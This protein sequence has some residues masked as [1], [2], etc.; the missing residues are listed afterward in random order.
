M[1]RGFPCQ[2]WLIAEARRLA[3]SPSLVSCAAAAGLVGRLWSP[4]EAARVRDAVMPQLLAGDGPRARSRTW[5][6]ALGEAERAGIEGGGIVRALSLERE[7]RPLRRLVAARL[8]DA[9]DLALSWLHARDDLACVADVLPECD[10][11]RGALADLDRAATALLSTWSLVPGLS[12]DER[13][14]AVSWQDPEAWWGS[15]CQ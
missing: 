14:R 12:R 5:G 3:A 11:L 7:L 9:G 15:L 4:P 10:A 6:R 1:I 8:A 13:L 2:G